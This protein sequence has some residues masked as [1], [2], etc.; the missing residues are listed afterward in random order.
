VHYYRELREALAAHLPSTVELVRGVRAAGLV[1]DRTGRVCGVRTAQR[2]R[3]D[4]VTAGLTVGCEGPGSPSRKDAGLSTGQVRRY[5]HDLFGFDVLHPPPL[6]PYLTAF[7]T[8]AGLRLVYPMGPPDERLS[9][10]T[11][12]YLPPGPGCGASVARCT[13]T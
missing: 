8:R 1:R 11:Q 5:P 9:G 10:I 4:V 13:S 6:S 7:V 3:P 12:R 2:G